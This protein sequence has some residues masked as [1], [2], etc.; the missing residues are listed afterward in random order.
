MKK[1][2]LLAIVVLGIS[3]V[4][5]GQ[6]QTEI[7]DNTAK[8]EIIKTLTLSKVTGG[9]LDFGK[10]GSPK[11][12]STVILA[13]ANGARS[14]SA[15]LIGSNGTP[16]KFKATG[17]KDY[18]MSV[19]YPTD[20]IHLKGPTGSTDMLIKATT[21]TIDKTSNTDIS[22]DTNGEA[23]FNIGATLTVNPDQAVGQYTGVYAIS[24]NYN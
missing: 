19:T 18:R 23:L 20:D 7:T 8:A 17:D 24:V 4:S 13:A 11:Q 22:F 6:A 12:E 16:A 5:F 2:L 21:W 9:N 14:G 10:I 3:A 15:D 1:L